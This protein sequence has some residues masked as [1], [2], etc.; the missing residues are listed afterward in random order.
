MT[1]LTPA[2]LPMESILQ[3]GQWSLHQDISNETD[4]E[5][6]GSV[7]RLGLLRPPIVR[8]GQDGYELVCGVKRLDALRRLGHPTGSIGCSVLSEQAQ[9]EDIL[10][11][12]AEDQ[13]QTGPLSPIEA[14]RFINLVNE[15]LTQPN[16]ELFNL[17][18]ATT[19]TTQRN[20]LLSLL[21][22]EEP[23]RT[24]IHH[25]KISIKTGLNFV[26]LPTAERRFIHDLFIRL[27][28]NGNKQ[29]R[30]LE[31]MQI[32]TGVEGCTVVK[33]IS[34]HFPELCREPISNIPQQTTHLMK[35]LYEHSHPGISLAKEE[36]VKRVAK[37][38][39]PKNCRVSPTPAFEKDSVTLEVEFDDFRTF[40]EAW[41]KMK[42]FV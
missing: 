30:F 11:L 24:S 23:I 2:L 4:D 42:R 18:S 28:L 32:I 33:F 21:E 37:M 41:Q 3:R 12:I 8:L 10:S 36:F 34:N 5:F 19:S 13:I 39:L 6:I 25:G 15:Q 38:K 20:Q 35:R 9:A 16:N 26:S 40:S 31:L 17:A 7:E 22:L 1:L 14:A 29:R 27:S